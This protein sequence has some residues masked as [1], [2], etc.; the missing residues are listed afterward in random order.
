MIIN[1]GKAKLFQSVLILL[2]D[3]KKKMIRP[4]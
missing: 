4:G 1:G 2:K 3:A